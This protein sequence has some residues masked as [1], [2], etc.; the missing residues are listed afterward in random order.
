MANQAR[1]DLDNIV[2]Q[3]L[4]RV[5]KKLLDLSRRNNLINFRETRRTI[6]IIDE[7]PDETFRL[8]VADG[9]SLELL[10]FDPPD[11]IECSTQDDETLK[12]SRIN[13]YNFSCCRM[14]A[15]EATHI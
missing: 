4:E 1:D 13:Q 5:R 2:N 6:R 11:E 8:L 15:Q 7:L 3:T 12:H 14:C 10:S 9:K